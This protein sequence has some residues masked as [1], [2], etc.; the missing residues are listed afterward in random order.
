VETR[1]E[2]AVAAIPVVI[3]QAPIT[4]VVLENLSVSGFIRNYRAVAME[5]GQLSDLP[6]VLGA[7]ANVGFVQDFVVSLQVVLA[8]LNSPDLLLQALEVLV[9]FAQ[10]DK[11]AQIMQQTGFT[12]YCETLQTYPQCA[13]VALKLQQSLD[14]DLR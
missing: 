2:D 11:C 14:R 3:E 10:Y 5:L 7:L 6:F 8:A 13:P 9:R 12:R 4:A 1:D